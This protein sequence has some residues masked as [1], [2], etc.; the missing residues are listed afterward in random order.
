MNNPPQAQEIV[1]F[2]KDALKQVI[3]ILERQGLN[4]NDWSRGIGL[5]FERYHSDGYYRS[6]GDFVCYY[7]LDPYIDLVIS[8]PKPGAEKY[9][10]LIE[11]V[12]NRSANTLR[13]SFTLKMMQM[14][15]PY[16]RSSR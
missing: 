7:E 15:G 1:Y 9:D 16:I 8:K 4:I 14:I 6:N 12:L 10:W 13:D 11:K 3:S 2:Q 5:Q